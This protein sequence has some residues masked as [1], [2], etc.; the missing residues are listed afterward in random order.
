[1]KKNNVIGVFGLGISGKSIIEYYSKTNIKIYA[2]DDKDSSYF[3]ATNTYFKNYT[4]WPWEKL[5]FL[6]FSPGI[7]LNYPEPHEIVKLARKYNIKIICD[8]ECLF[9]EKNDDI[10]LI[11]ITGTNGK[12]TTTALINHILNECGVSSEIGGNFGIPAMSLDLVAKGYKVIEISS[13][14]LDLLDKTIFDYSLL[15]NI[16]PD[17]IDRHGNFENYIKAKERVFKGVNADNCIICIDQ[18]ITKEIFQR[19]GNNLTSYQTEIFDELKTYSFP[20]LPGEHNLQNIIGAYLICKKIG[21]KN[22]DIINAIKSFK[23][24]EHRI[25]LV[26]ENNNYLAINDSKATNADATKPALKTFDNII[27]L[28]GGVAKDGGIEDLSEYFDKIETAIFFGE[29]KQIFKNSFQ[30]KSNK[31]IFI[32]KNLQKAVEKAF[33]IVNI[34]RGKKYTILL[35]PACASFDEFKNYEE[36]GQFFKKLV[37]NNIF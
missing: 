1:M 35:S 27:W 9:F 3:E 10:K 32:E 14:Q 8:I 7:P 4:K 29:A 30:S 11:G 2:D 26:T 36:R 33:E 12:S 5:D 20:N 19:N 15:L 24:L 17:H 18:K 28:A 25:E 37:L 16:T 13:Y 22:T 23:G 6:V 21:L 34:K 31:K